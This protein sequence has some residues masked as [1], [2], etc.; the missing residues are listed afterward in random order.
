MIGIQDK[1]LARV[2]DGFRKAVLPE[3]RMRWGH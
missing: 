1:D 3:W 2:L